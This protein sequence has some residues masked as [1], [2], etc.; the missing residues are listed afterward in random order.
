MAALR[1]LN[2]CRS[3]SPYYVV[4]LVHHQVC[5]MSTY[6]QI[7]EIFS[8]LN[9]VHINAEGYCEKSKEYILFMILFWQAMSIMYRVNDNDNKF[10]KYYTCGQL[11]A[12]RIKKRAS[13]WKKHQPN[14]RNF[15]LI[16]LVE[17]FLVTAVNKLNFSISFELLRV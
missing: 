9:H 16:D 14:L 13:G 1:C 12:L 3:R 10:V 8:Q 7:K 15:Y 6:R 5:N 17:K 4:A 11:N 2:L